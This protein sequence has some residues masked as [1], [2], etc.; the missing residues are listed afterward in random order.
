MFTW[1]DWE[2]ENN[3][4]I[5]KIL[6]WTQLGSMLYHCPWWILSNSS[7]CIWDIWM[8]F[9]P[10]AAQRHLHTH[11][12]TNFSTTDHIK[13]CFSRS[14]WQ[15]VF[16]MSQPVFWEQALWRAGTPHDMSCCSQKGVPATT[17]ESIPKMTSL[18]RNKIILDFIL[19]ISRWNSQLGSDISWIFYD[20]IPKG[21]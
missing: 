12:K 7:A 16:G 21:F 15:G 6:S 10:F 8:Y 1:E 18:K 14:N 11:R 5:L 2:L 17:K 20:F 9:S 3:Y 13:S 4:I 19:F